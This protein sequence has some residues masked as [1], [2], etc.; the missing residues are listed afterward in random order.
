MG[1]EIR[2]VIEIC[3]AYDHGN[4]D[5]HVAGGMV[6]EFGPAAGAWVGG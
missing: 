5:G 2:M 3:S 1:L 6:I 4:E